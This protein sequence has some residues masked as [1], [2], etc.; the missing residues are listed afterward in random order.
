MMMAIPPVW[1]KPRWLRAW[2]R[3]W[4]GSLVLGVGVFV[5]INLLWFIFQWG[6]EEYKDAITDL[7]ILPV[8]LATAGLA[9][10]ASSHAALD[11]KTRR[12][13]RLIALGSLLYWIGGLFWTYYEVILHT[14]PFPSWADA[15]YLS[16]YPLVLG[17]LLSFPVAPHTKTDR[18]KFWLDIG[19]VLLG[20]GM[21]IWYFILRPTAQVEYS[22]PLPAVL[23]LAYPVGDLVLLFGI[24]AVL[25]RRPQDSSRGALHLLVAGLIP[26]F[27]GDLIFGYLNLQGV[28][29]SGGWADAL[30]LIGFFLM[31]LSGQ[32]QY[33]RA[34]QSAIVES[35]TPVQARTLTL[36]P[37]L[38]VVV[39]YGLLLFVA[40]DLWASTLGQLIIGAVALTALVVARQIVAVRENIRL[41]EAQAAHRSEARIR[42]LVQNSS[43]V[44]MIVTP[45]GVIEYITPSVEH[46]V[47]YEAD[48]LVGT[49]FTDLLHPDD[50]AHAHTFLVQAIARLGPTPVVEWRM[51]HRT[52]TWLHIETIGNNVCYDSTIQGIVLT[53]RDVTERK[54]KE[55]AEQA[56]QAKS[57]FL[58]NMSHELRTPLNAIIGYSEMLQEEAEDV[59]LAAF[60]P[61][62]QK[63]HTAGHHLLSLIND[64]LDLS[65]IE[66]GKM[67]LYVEAFEVGAVLNSVTTTIR[68]LIEKNANTLHLH[69]APDVGVMQTDLTKVRQILLNLLGNA[70]K[71]TRAG[72]ITLHVTREAGPAGAWLHFAVQDT[73]IGMTVEQVGKLFQPFTQADASTTRRYGGTGLGLALSQR[74]CELLGGT[75]SVDSTPGLGST[76]TV[77]LPVEPPQH[78]PQ[79]ALAAQ[80]DTVAAQQ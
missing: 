55:A 67:D 65:K 3:D 35:A 57:M 22:G 40:H 77:H 6:G 25:F 1:L 79:T 75:I 15:G 26:F 20:G 80:A 59:G 13:W 52:N 61:D 62:L 48:E 47:G 68:P 44:I 51:R 78:V 30:W 23:A 38:A 7:A 63:I 31:L 71:F 58:A 9:W 56:N 17:G 73:G 28:F 2:S 53:T 10:R 16:F 64:I 39:G 29:Q 8:E 14:N 32:Y 45:M 33:W 11:R 27:A 41:Q 72:T 37:Y 24:I 21:A 76:F 46:V 50:S 34:S 49:P 42:S 69:A 66:A 60:I 12:A 54:A 74:L 5:L 4:G 43:D 36:L 18:V 19:I 70:A